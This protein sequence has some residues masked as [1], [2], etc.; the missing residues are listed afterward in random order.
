M[1]DRQQSHITLEE[2]Y[3]NADEWL[4]EMS[5]INQVTLNDSGVLH[6]STS[7]T[8]RDRLLFFTLTPIN[9]YF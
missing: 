9:A 8:N 6:D 5:G 1:A 3:E 7:F 2:A 4:L